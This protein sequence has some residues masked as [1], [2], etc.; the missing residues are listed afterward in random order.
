MNI[1]VDD[2]IRETKRELAQRAHVYPRMI[3]RNALTQARADNQIAVLRAIL[4]DYER[5]K[6]EREPGLKL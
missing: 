6:A 1:T 5:Q 2:K 3:A 4:A